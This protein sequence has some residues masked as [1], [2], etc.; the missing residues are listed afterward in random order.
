VEILTQSVVEEA[1]EIDP[2]H[3]LF[4]GRGLFEPGVRV[5]EDT[6]WNEQRVETTRQGILLVFACYEV[7]LKEKKK[8]FVSPDF[9][10]W[11]LEIIFS[12]NLF[13]V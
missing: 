5:L 1:D 2:E 12:N 10:A 13:N 4:E 8:L 9:M 6:D 11:F 7:I 3:Q